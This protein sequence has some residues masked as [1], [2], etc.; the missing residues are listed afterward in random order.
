ME[1]LIEED[2]RTD[3]RLIL[4]TK[5]GIPDDLIKDVKR[6]MGVEEILRPTGYRLCLTISKLND[7]FEVMEKIKDLLDRKYL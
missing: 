7:K 4:H 1:F 3:N 6:I 5:R 2:E